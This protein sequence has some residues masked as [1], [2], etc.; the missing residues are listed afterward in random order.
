MTEPTPQR[1][2]RAGPIV[3]LIVAAAAIYA[4]VVATPVGGLV[5]RGVNW[6][7]DRPD[8]GRALITYFKSAGLEGTVDADAVR[9][10]VETAPEDA[11]TTSAATAA[12]VD[13]EVARALALVLSG[14]Q[15]DG[16]HFDVR[17]PKAAVASFAAVGVR[18][19]TAS[20]SAERRQLV[21]LQGVGALQRE[22][23]VSEAA[24][25]AVAVDVSRVR[26]ALRR[27]RAAGGGL[28]Y[29]DFRRFLPPDQRAAAD[30]VV[31]GTFALAT[32]F[33]MDWPVSP[34]AR[35]S[36]KFGWRRHPVLGKRKKHTGIDLAVPVGTPVKAIA[37]GRVRY[38]GHDGVNGR[39]VK[40]DHGHGLTSIYC[41]N[42]A[43]LVGR[44]ATVGQGDA[45]AKSGATG[46]VSGPHLH[47]QME[48][49]DVP[50][51]PAIFYRTTGTVAVR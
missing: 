25:A 17:L 11:S 44:G 4:L 50:V 31:H 29:G 35:V 5:V 3:D 48:I 30:R 36:S 9:A 27:A 38:V 49:D 1:R 42:D 46:R 47:F 45:I 7:L 41:H 34:R 22:L 2:R 26:F 20:A 40:L 51:D 43:V 32:A 13:P 14:G 19:P 6:A 21:L 24:V 15:A 23:T 37:P 16:D 12:G 28:Q 33:R 8:G 39:Y 10:A 18:V